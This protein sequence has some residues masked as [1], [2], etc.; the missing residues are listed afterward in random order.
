[1]SG[2]RRDASDR[3]DS[4]SSR[5][6]DNGLVR[7]EP[8]GH[9]QLAEIQ[10]ARILAA[11][12]EVVAE[13]GV[14]HTTIAHVVARSGVSRRTFYELFEDREDCFLAAFDD[15]IEQIATVVI[16][17]YEQPDAWRERI[18][19]GLASLLEL[20]DREPALARLTVVETLG[21]GPNALTRRRRAL[22]PVIAAV[23]EGRDQAKDKGGPP[24]LA[25]EG[26]VG[27]AFS[28]VHARVL[29][30]DGPPL[31]E[32]LNPLMSM[33]VLPYLGAA[34]ARKELE[35][36]LP[37]PDRT[38]RPRPDPLRGLGMRLT[39]RTVR[40]LIA[41]AQTPG[42]SN[43]R[44]GDAAGVS[45]QGQ[46]SKLLARLTSLGLVENAGA[47][48]ARGEPN[49]WRLTRKGREVEQALETRATRR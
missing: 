28:L 15:A 17:A 9:S 19:S 46:I 13:R 23:D 36:P 10:R 37:E 14:G 45:D 41:V 4:G 31:L 12:V 16:P 47:N 27:G 30:E 20:L 35:R 24:A 21:A 32:L 25:A 33:I 29:Q 38:R 39:Y 5:P 6:S 26:A 48:S 7:E 2:R 3:L 22:A 18:R 49:A 11:M 42:A 1:M 43:R 8:D 44:L 40:V 34:A